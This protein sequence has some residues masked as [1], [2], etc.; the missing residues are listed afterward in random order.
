MKNDLAKAISEIKTIFE[1]SFLERKI[2][3]NFL[4]YSKVLE[5]TAKVTCLQ[6]SLLKMRHMKQ[7]KHDNSGF[8][9]PSENQDPSKLTIDNDLTAPDLSKFGSIGAPNNSLGGV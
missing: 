8:V 3:I 9:F 5:E 6:L 1:A 4:T 7:L 2:V